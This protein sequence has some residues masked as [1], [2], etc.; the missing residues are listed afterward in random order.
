MPLADG[1]LA[2]NSAVAFPSGGPEY[3]GTGIVNSGFP[4]D[5]AEGPVPFS[6][7]FSAAGTFELVC[8]VHPHMKGN[9]TVLSAGSAAPSSQ[10]AVTARGQGE[11]ADLVG[12]AEALLAAEEVG[13]TQRGDNKEY[14]LLSGL[15]EGKVEYLRFVPQSSL[16][17]NVGDTVTWDWGR[18]GAPHTVTFLSGAEAPPGIVPEPQA[19]GPPILLIN[20]E[21][22]APSGGSAYSG[23]GVF[24]SGLL[25]G[26]NGPPGVPTTYSLTFNEPGS[27][28]YLCMLHPFMTGTITVRG[29][30]GVALLATGDVTLPAAVLG[31]AA[32]L[33]MGLATSGGFIVWRR[34]K[35]VAPI[36]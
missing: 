23:T 31:V 32:L 3:D 36:E 35:V 1:R 25:L 16:S 5:D 19:G 8:L 20:P 7:T 12:Q 27:H 28:K 29:R 33:G 26:P 17:I 13:T 18:T 9:V 14:T 30:A 15:D 22:A 2:L 4:P 34:R 21:V 24:S 6:I 11:L 10:A